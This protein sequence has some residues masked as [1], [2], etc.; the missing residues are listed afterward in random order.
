MRLNDRVAIITGGANGIGK[1]TAKRFA[2]E[3]DVFQE[4]SNPCD[5]RWPFSCIVITA[6]NQR[7]LNSRNS[8]L[9]CLALYLLDFNHCGMYTPKETYL[10]RPQMRVE[11][12]LKLLQFDLCNQLEEMLGINK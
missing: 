10:E 9:V 5:I 8:F 12:F 3:G 1:A 4:V 11:Q 7:N 2:E 6:D